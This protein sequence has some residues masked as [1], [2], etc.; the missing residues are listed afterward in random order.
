MVQCLELLVTTG[1][2]SSRLA[3]SR[4]T[5]DLTRHQLLIAVQRAVQRQNGESLALA[6]VVALLAGW[7][8]VRKTLPLNKILERVLT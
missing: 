7:E 1:P 2:S 6:P 5:I 8:A 3:L 4:A